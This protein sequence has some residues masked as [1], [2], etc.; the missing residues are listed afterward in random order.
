MNSCPT[1]CCSL[2]ITTG[3]AVL[4]QYLYATDPTATSITSATHATFRHAGRSRRLDHAQAPRIYKLHEGTY[5]VILGMHRSVRFVQVPYSLQHIRC[6]LIVVLTVNF[7]MK[8]NKLQSCV[9]IVCVSHMVV[10]LAFPST[11]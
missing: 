8:K 1:L 6:I 3:L 9:R 10:Y 2:T 5:L 4:C 7:Y 11:C